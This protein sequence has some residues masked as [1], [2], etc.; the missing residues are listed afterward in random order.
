MSFIKN[1][2]LN[3]FLL[4]GKKKVSEKILNHFLLDGKKK[5]SEKILLQSFKELQKFSKKQSRK[6]IQLAII[7][8]MPV[9][10]ITKLLRK[11]RK[12][13]FTKEVPKIIWVERVKTSLAIKFILNGLKNRKLNR[14]YTKFYTEIFSTAKNEGS[15]VQTKNEIQKKV[16][17]KKHFIFNHNW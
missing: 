2:Q 17:I 5:V 10:R 11:R 1:K 9:F 8:S 6:L 16:L 14:F 12:K 3:S 7:R 13:K 15:V 4:G